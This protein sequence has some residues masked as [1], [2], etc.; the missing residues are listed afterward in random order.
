ML[1]PI[2]LVLSFSLFLNSCI[3]LPVSQYTIESPSKDTTY[4]GIAGDADTLAPSPTS[5]ALP[6]QLVISF[7]SA[8]SNI[9][10][11]LNGNRIDLT[12][13]ESQ[14]TAN[15][16]D[17]K[18]FLRQGE[19][20]IIVDPLGFGPQLTFF[21]DSQAPELIIK[22]V[23]KNSGNIN[24]SGAL[25]DISAPTS[26]T[27]Y[28]FDYK[29]E[30]DVVVPIDSQGNTLSINSSGEVIDDSGNNIASIDFG[31]GSIQV[32]DLNPDGNNNFSIN[33][34]EAP[35]YQFVLEDENGYRDQVLYL[36]ENQ[37]INPV[38]KFRLNESFLEQVVP[39]ANELADNVQFHDEETLLFRGKEAD[40][41]NLVDR[42]SED[43]SL[44]RSI[45]QNHTAIYTDIGAANSNADACH[46]TPLTLTC[47]DVQYFNQSSG[48]FS[49][50]NDFTARG[51]NQGALG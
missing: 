49:R 14:V 50:G 29:L 51:T 22:A 44:F 30:G 39:I 13:G 17:L 43:N 38:F 26:A 42:G 25:R 34:P 5:E 33:L 37:R 19:N 46:E 20:Q 18:K 27:L 35:A 2:L 31:A 6:E 15:F 40:L 1:K 32:V 47:T 11:Q 10:V 9:D 28:T 21:Y 16:S 36:A 41:N 3:D 23:E 4:I 12:Y 7:T 24:I 48:I 8:T 45:N